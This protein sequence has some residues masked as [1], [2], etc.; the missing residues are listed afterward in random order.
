MK[1]KG[2]VFLF[3]FFCLMFIFNI[4]TPLLNDDY[5]VS[6]IW[7]MGGSINALPENAK[8]IAK[9]EFNLKKGD[10][11]VVTGGFPLGQTRT[12]NYLRIM[13]I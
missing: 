12:T 10:L 4:F 7:P 6:F 11:I 1:Y 5:F 8:R 2:L 9:E 13:E 3:L